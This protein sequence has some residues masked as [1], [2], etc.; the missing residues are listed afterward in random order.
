MMIA[1]MMTNSS[2]TAIAGSG[3]DTWFQ[4]YAAPYE[5]QNRFMLE[6][7]ERAGSPVVVLTTDAVGRGN[8]EGERWFRKD[9]AMNDFPL[10]NYAGYTGKRGVG[11]PAM[12]WQFV[13]WLKNNTKGGALFVFALH[14]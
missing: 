1:S 2:Y 11:D 14:D 12:T 5:T 9:S 7:A 8:R 3:A 4:M 6:M 10:G 13:E